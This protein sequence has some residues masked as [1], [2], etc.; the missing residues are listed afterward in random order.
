MNVAAGTL[1]ALV[2][3]FKL[4]PDGRPR[5]SAPFDW[6]GAVLYSVGLAAVLS[7]FSR[8][9]RWPGL[10]LLATGAA[11]L[12][13]FVRRERGIADPLLDVRLFSRN[14]VFAFSNLAALINYA[15]TYAVGF[16]LS[17]YLQNVRGLGAQAA[18]LLLVA[19][20][21]VQAAVS[22]FAGRLSDR[23]APRTLA[24]AGMAVIVCG[25]AFLSFLDA[26]TSMAAVAGW[27]GVLGSVSGCSRPPIPAP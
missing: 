20:P 8:L 19:Q 2:A 15:A 13:L 1:T 27:L 11:A 18:G 21:L 4:P 16:L 25:L 22:P 17:L 24:S 10:V 23:V 5:L 12:A 9:P 26:R 6:P 7:G 3:A 14:R